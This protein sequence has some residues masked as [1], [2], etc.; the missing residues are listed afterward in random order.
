MPKLLRMP[1]LDT[2]PEGPVRDFVELLFDYHHVA[3][4]PTLE[5][6]CDQIDKRPDEER[7][8][9]AS[10]ETVR[11]MFHGHAPRHWQTVEV[12][13]VALCQLADVDP[14]RKVKYYDE[15]QD[16]HVVTD[17]RSQMHD[18]WSAALYGR[19]IGKSLFRGVNFDYEEPEPAPPTRNGYQPADDPWA[20]GRGGFSDDPPF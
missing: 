6:V 15:Q 8:G 4:H 16:E 12:V 5:E 1:N 3:H 18:A 17:R 20:T 13:F 2:L 11:R 19:P 14:D 7:S 9:T 10:R